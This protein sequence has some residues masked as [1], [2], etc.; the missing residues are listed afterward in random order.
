LTGPST[1]DLEAHLL[2]TE[3]F[4]SRIVSAVIGLVL[5]AFS[6]GLT[7][8]GLWAAGKALAPSTSRLRR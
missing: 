1:A 6:L 4:L 8:Y 3:A 2:G 5:L 7:G